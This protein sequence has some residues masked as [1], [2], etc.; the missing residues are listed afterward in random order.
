MVLLNYLY[1]I[2]S[3]GSTQEFL[4]EKACISAVKWRFSSRTLAVAP[5]LS[6]SSPLPALRS[7]YGDASV[8]SF[9][10]SMRGTCSFVWSPLLICQTGERVQRGKADESPLETIIIIRLL[11]W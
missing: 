11:F 3:F 5:A 2:F 9:M 6:L 7:L 1:R 8:K 4:R 10:H